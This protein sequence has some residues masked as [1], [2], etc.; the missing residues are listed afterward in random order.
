MYIENI[1]RGRDKK[2]SF[3]STCAIVYIYV[4]S[5]Q[6]LHHSTFILNIPFRRL[7]R[8]YERYFHFKHCYRIRERSVDAN[9]VSG[10][11]YP[12]LFYAYVRLIVHG[13]GRLPGCIIRHQRERKVVER[14]K[15]REGE[16]KIKYK[17]IKHNQEV[18]GEIDS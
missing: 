6:Y 9:C 18:D 3:C 14:R 16:R 5:L 13:S 8:Y 1:Q 11:A 2:P 17:I 10:D 15:E 12:S 7:S 4:F